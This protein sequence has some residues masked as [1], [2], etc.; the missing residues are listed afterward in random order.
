MHGDRRGDLAVAVWCRYFRVVP[1]L[2]VLD[3][4]EPVEPLVDPVPEPLA[5]PELVVSDELPVVPLEP[6]P[7]MPVVPPLVEPDPVL[8][9]PIVLPLPVVPD[10]EPLRLGDVEVDP[11]VLPGL[12]VERV[13]DDELEVPVSRPDVLSRSEQAPSA[14]V[15]TVA[16]TA[17]PSA[18]NFICFI[19]TPL[20]TG[21]FPPGPDARVPA[22]PERL[23]GDPVPSAMHVPRFPT[24]TRAA[25]RVG[26]PPP[27]REPCPRPLN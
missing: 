12:V 27:S 11:L 20:D 1:D 10:V 15:A 14:N 22:P 16:A 18:R 23:G 17:T 13:D 9:L 5:D 26:P 25:P 21:R 3:V 4:S 7:L 2:V 19:F 6:E 24:G 8:P